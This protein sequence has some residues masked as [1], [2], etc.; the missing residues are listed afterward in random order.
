MTMARLHTSWIAMGTWASG[1]SGDTGEGHFGGGF[2][3]AADA[4][5]LNTRGWREKAA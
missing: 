5:A 1:D 3:E 4:A 2:T